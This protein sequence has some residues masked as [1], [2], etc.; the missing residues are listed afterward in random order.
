M[1]PDTIRRVQHVREEDAMEA[2]RASEKRPSPPLDVP[3]GPLRAGLVRATL[4]ILRENTRWWLVPLI[5]ALVLV[6]AMHFG[7]RSSVPFVY[8][9]F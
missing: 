3:R 6:A 5:L 4:T 7:A 2:P 8:T 9:L 1:R